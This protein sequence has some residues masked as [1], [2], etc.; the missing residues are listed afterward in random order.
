[1]DGM[2]FNIE[3]TPDSIKKGLE[4]CSD[5]DMQW[6]NCE[7]CLYGYFGRCSTLLHEDALDYI[8]QLEEQ[9]EKLE[10][11]VLRGRGEL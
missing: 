10:K 3:R 5:K 7:Q 2:M 1:M 4:C 9:V 8:Q 6:K 11:D